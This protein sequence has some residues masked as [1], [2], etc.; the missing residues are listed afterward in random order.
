MTKRQWF[1]IFVTLA[2]LAGGMVAGAAW[3]FMHPSNGAQ[4]SPFHWLIFAP[5]FVGAIVAAF[6]RNTRTHRTSA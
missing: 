5:I 1:L 6:R 2:A 3:R 4:P